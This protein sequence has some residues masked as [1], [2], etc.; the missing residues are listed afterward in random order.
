MSEG[1][2]IIYQLC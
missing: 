2:L 1:K